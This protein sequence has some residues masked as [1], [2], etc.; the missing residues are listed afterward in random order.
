MLRAES[1]FAKRIP[2]RGWQGQLRTGIL[3]LLAIFLVGCSLLPS[4][5]TGVTQPPSPTE[6]PSTTPFTPPT[7]QPGEEI[8]GDAVKLVIWLPPEFDPASGTAAGNSLSARLESFLSEH[9]EA[10][11]EIRLKARE[12]VGGLLDALSTASAAAPS[13]LPDLIALPR[14]MMETAALKGLLRPFDDLTQIQLATDWYPFAN[15]MA[16]LQNNTFGLPFAG[17]A[18]LLAYHPDSDQDPLFTWGET[19]TIS[20]T[21]AFP[22]SDPQ[23][24][25]P[26]SLYLAAGGKILDAQGRPALDPVTLTRVLEFL[27]YA[28]KAG[29]LPY[30]D[31]QHE[32][33]DQSWEAFT[34]GEVDQTIGWSSRYLSPDANLYN[35]VQVSLLPS[36]TQSG[37]TMITGWVWALPATQPIRQ[38]LSAQLAEHLVDSAFLVQWAEAAGYIPTRSTAMPEWSRPDTR[39][40]VEQIAATAHPYPPA[41]VLS[42][43]GPVLKQATLDVL[44][45]QQTPQQ[46]AEKAAEDLS[47]K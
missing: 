38:S 16:R 6:T 8:P 46:A 35:D 44:T 25:F 4:G 43:L 12:G 41:D 19:T 42:A 31:L 32:T 17:D 45:Q 13:A 29:S 30:W 18:L 1:N 47:V 3:F 34:Q 20:G 37:F 26:L 11:I 36:P 22:A 7:A 15:E 2:V 14:P 9:P 27:S 10:R 33:F 5:Q 24:L 21:L 39:V 23:A 28:E 40:L